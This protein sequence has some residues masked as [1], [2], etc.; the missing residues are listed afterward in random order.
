MLQEILKQYKPRA[1]VVPAEL[2]FTDCPYMWPFCRQPL[3]ANAM[4][5]M[6]NA[7]VLNGMG[8]IG[9]P[10][11]L[12]SHTAVHPFILVLVSLD[13]TPPGLVGLC[14]TDVRCGVW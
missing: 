12:P 11:R 14:L 7:T 8:L 9:E 4:P 6:F 5:L 3:Y 13:R 1:S 10:C 2:D